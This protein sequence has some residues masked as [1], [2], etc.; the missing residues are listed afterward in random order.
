M[1]AIGLTVTI[2]DEPLPPIRANL[3]HIR[4]VYGNVLDNAVKY[5]PEGGQVGV[6]LGQE[7]AFIQFRV[8]D[9]GAGISEEDLPQIGKRFYRSDKARSRKTEGT[10]LG[11]NLAKSILDLYG[12]EIQISS[13][14]LKQGTTVVIA[15]P[16][17]AS[18]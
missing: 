2:E 9:D 16:A 17:S 3:N 6:T 18:G 15:W 1:A 12:G 14:G 10:G 8:M 7:G 4:V 5:T 13:D 11:L